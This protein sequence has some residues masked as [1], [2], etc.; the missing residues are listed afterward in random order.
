MRN[1]RRGSSDHR[2]GARARRWSSFY[3]L[4]FLFAVAAAPHRHL[5]SLEDLVSEGPS[6]SGS[7]LE[8]G[9]SDPGGE[10]RIQAARLV[11][12]DPCMACFH[13]DY[14]ASASETFV[15]DLTFAALRKI[16]ALPG[17]E[18]PEPVSGFSVSR[19]PPSLL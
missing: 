16:P 9:P 13:H 4:G 6:D 15:F 5:N 12:D 8:A 3:L 11:D 7:F 1:M 10:T 18:M 17:L 19:S 2:F 14:S